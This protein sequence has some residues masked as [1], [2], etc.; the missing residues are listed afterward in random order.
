MAQ[1]STAVALYQA[2]ESLYNAF[3]KVI[4]IE[5]GGCYHSVVPT[6]QP[7]SLSMNDILNKVGK[8]VFRAPLHSSRRH[9]KK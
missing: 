1:I 7:L 5:G 2:G 8:I 6:T 9:T 3:D 4:A